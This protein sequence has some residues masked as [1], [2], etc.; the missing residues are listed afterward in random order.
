MPFAFC[1]AGGEAAEALVPL[2]EL[3]RKAHGTLCS[4]PHDM[5]VETKSRGARATRRKERP[6]QRKD[7]AKV[8]CAIRAPESTGVPLC[9]ALTGHRFLD[10]LLELQLALSPASILSP[11]SLRPLRAVAAEAAGSGCASVRGGQRAALV[12]VQTVKRPSSYAARTP[13]SRPAWRASKRPTG[14]YVCA[15]SQRAPPCRRRLAAPA[16]RVRRIRKSVWSPR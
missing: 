10:L 3:H 9:V 8:P 4:L 13:H 1:R 12:A 11:S 14:T 15:T 16:M 5:H 2:D 7:S 6:V